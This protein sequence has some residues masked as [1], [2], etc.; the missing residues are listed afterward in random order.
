VQTLSRRLRSKD[1]RTPPAPPI[2][3]YCID[4]GDSALELSQWACRQAEAIPET[5][6]A[7]DHGDR[8]RTIER[9]VLHSVV[10]QKNVELF[11]TNQSLRGSDPIRADH[12]R[13][14][15]RAGD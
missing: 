2:D 15:G 1:A 6:L 12:H 11:C 14:T 13:T 4:I 7:I 10:G 8:Q 9:V 3:N 5:P